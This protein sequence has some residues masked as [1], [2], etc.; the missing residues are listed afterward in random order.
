[1]NNH[2]PAKNYTEE[3]LQEKIA[4]AVAV[5]AQLKENLRNQI[6]TY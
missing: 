1:M 2:D 6:V 4:A 3:E 5:S